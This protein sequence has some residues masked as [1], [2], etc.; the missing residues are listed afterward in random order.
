MTSYR[1]QRFGSVVNWCKLCLC[2]IVSL[3]TSLCIQGQSAPDTIPKSFFAKSTGIGQ[4][5]NP[6]KLRKI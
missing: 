2:F 6:G 1:H 4:K 3:T 5:R